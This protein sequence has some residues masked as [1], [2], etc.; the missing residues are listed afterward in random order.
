M[1]D[2]RLVGLRWSLKLCIVN[3]LPSDR[4]TAVNSKTVGFLQDLLIFPSALHPDFSYNCCYSQNCSLKQS[5]LFIINSS[6]QII[7]KKNLNM[8]VEYLRYPT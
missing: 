4:G 6:L 7:E 5:H 8:F 2:A 3:K 1:R